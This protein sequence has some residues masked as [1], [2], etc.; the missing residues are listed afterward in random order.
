MCTLSLDTG[1]NQTKEGM[2]QPGSGLWY[3]GL[4]SLQQPFSIPRFWGCT[5]CPCS[6]TQFCAFLQ[7]KS[8]WMPTLVC[9]CDRD[10]WPLP[11]MPPQD[12]CSWPEKD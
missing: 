4:P 5:P 9:R 11:L 3:P 10:G 7:L 1:V 12:G 6:R 8:P 2:S